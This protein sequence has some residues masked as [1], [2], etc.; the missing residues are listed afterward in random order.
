MTFCRQQVSPLQI[1]K[2]Q[3]SSSIGDQ[4]MREFSLRQCWSGS[5]PIEYYWF[6]RTKKKGLHSDQ[7]FKWLNCSTYTSA[8]QN[9]LF[10]Y[11]TI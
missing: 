1:K 6:R 2:W 3:M 9:K 11:P 5:Y 10:C 7:S 4:M 8:R